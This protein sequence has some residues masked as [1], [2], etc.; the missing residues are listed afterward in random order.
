MVQVW[1]EAHLFVPCAPPHYT[2]GRV[3]SGLVICDIVSYEEISI[4]GSIYLDHPASSIIILI[5]ILNNTEKTKEKG[6]HVY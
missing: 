3:V 4:F 1:W 6:G 2:T 5:I